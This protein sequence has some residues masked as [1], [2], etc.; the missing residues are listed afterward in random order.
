MPS[1]GTKPLAQVTCTDNLVKFGHV[2]CGI[3]EQTDKQTESLIAI[4]GPPAGDKV[5]IVRTAIA[6]A[7]LSPTHV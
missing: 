5:S 3:R 2:V 6:G 1:E 4:L 7:F